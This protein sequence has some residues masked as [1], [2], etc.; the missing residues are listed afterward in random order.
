MQII[1]YAG[2]GGITQIQH[3]SYNEQL[4]WLLMFRC[5]LHPDLSRAS[6]IR[7]SL[8]KHPQRVS[9]SMKKFGT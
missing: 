9:V 2:G 8:T 6:Q 4:V 3:M 5:T 1:D 7:M